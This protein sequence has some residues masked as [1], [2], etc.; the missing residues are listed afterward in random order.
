MTASSN[1]NFPNSGHLDLIV[2]GEQSL[3]KVLPLIDAAEAA[4]VEV[5]QYR[6]GHEELRRR[7]A[8]YRAHFFPDHT[9][10]P[11]GSGVQVHE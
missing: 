11:S 10:P 9:V 7:L 6:Q 1:P 2:R 3:S 4:G 8:A 5:Q